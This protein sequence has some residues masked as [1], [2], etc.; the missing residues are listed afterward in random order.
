MNGTRL[1]IGLLAIVMLGA[2][3]TSQPAEEGR[4][5]ERHHERTMAEG[6][7]TIDQAIA[8]AEKRFKARVVRADAKN[9]GGRTV[10]V[11]RLLNESGR[12]WTVKVDAATG[13][14]R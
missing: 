7:I 2:A 3:G 1:L 14:V 13:A 5:G 12:V 11:L 9:E 6:G 4:R 10:Y 8:M